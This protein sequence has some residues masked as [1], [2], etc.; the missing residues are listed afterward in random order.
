MPLTPNLSSL[1]PENLP[2]DLSLLPQ[3]VYIVGGCVRNALLGRKH[4]YFDVDLVLPSEAVETAQR[5]ARYYQAGFVIL[6]ETRQIARV[7][8]ES[9]TVDFAQQQGR[10]LKED[11]KRRDFRI[12]AIA[13]NPRTRKFIDPLKGRKDLEKKVITAIAKVNL[14]NDPLRLLRAYRQAAQL[15]FTIDSK[16]RTLIGQLAPNLARI[17]AERVRQELN[18]LLAEA[19]GDRWLHA[20]YEDGILS[21]FLE[22]ATEDSIKQIDKIDHAAW[23]LGK[24]W[25]DLEAELHRPIGSTTSSLSLAKLAS[26]VSPE[27][28]IAR[29]QLETLTY[30]RAEIRVVLNIL[31]HLPPILA[32]VNAPMSLETQYF[33]FQEVGDVFPA[34]AVFGVAV[35]ACRDV[36]QE[37]QAT[38]AIA[39]LVNA[40]LDP[41]NQVAHPTPLVTGN[42]LIHHLGL[43]PSRAIGTLLTQLQLARING[44]ISTPEEALQLAATLI[45]SPS[46]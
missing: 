26:L 18:Y 40:Y 15:D 4:P 36:L 22:N 43:R 42:D 7:V 46:S 19:K 13:Y 41:N 16:T 8:F 33:F 10:T 34:L 37:T 2:F 35:A 39:P 1:S 24:I 17:S 6:D 30:S 21:V 20:A 9:G 23:L 29:S 5:I 11:L 3:P 44:K 38:N 31:Q 32:L 14:E 45:P 28:K 12:N 25:V 27:V